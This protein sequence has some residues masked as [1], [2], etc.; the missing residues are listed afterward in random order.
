MTMANTINDLNTGTP[1]IDMDIH[2]PEIKP[3]SSIH[4]DFYINNILLEDI[5]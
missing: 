1:P 5:D 2:T 3:T 4:S